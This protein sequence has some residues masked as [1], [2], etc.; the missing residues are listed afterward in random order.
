MSSFNQDCE[1]TRKQCYSSFLTKRVRHD[2]RSKHNPWKSKRQWSYGVWGRCESFRWS[3]LGRS[4]L[5]KLLGSKE[6]LD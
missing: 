5:R 6:H 1:N 3:V 2:P 4:P